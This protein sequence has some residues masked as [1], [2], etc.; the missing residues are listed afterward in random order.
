MILRRLNQ[1]VRASLVGLVVLYFA[2]A[3]YMKQTRTV[4]AEPAAAPE[5]AELLAA[6]ASSASQVR[7]LWWKTLRGL[8]YK[9]GTVTDDLKSYDGTRVKIPGFMVPLEDDAEKVSE[10]LLVPYVGACIHTPPPPPNQIVHVK[11]A[12]NK[13]IPMYWYDP[14]WIE[15]EF[16]IKS[17]KSMYGD[18]AFTL[19]GQTQEMYKE[20]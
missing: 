14:V 1:I 20:K 2:V 9:K 12:G 15:G 19:N 11:M 6:A 5:A 7:E 10:F 3:L 4:L 18:V 13:S 17:V 16:K 8:D